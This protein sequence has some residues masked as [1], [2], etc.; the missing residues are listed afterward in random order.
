[1]NDISIHFGSAPRMD[2]SEADLYRMIS[3]PSSLLKKLTTGSW[4]S[5]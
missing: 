4:K 5:S 2:A 1:L 3:T